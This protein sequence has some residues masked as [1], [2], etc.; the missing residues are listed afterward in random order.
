MTSA[1]SSVGGAS[2]AGGASGASALSEDTKKK[3]KALGLDPTKYAT[4]ADA[5]LAIQET[6]S[7]QT[8][9]KPAGADNFKTVEEEAQALASEMGLPVGNN[10]KIDDIMDGISAKI[11]ELQSSAGSD[12]TKLSQLN[13]YNNKYTTISNELAQLQAAK[14][15]TGAT[16]L[17]NYNKA[18]LGL[19][20]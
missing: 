13:D 14:N 2:S 18:S 1:I 5:Q 9:Q 10:D 4:E 19:A 15:M 7:K 3:L 12:P 20:A 8:A 11:E 6:T 16:A 17:G